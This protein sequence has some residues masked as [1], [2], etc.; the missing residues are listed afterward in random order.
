MQDAKIGR[1][2]V[3]PPSIKFIFV[4]IIL[5]GLLGIGLYVNNVSKAFQASSL[6]ERAVISQSALEAKYGLRVNLVA[7]TAA[8]G[9]VDLRL[10]ITDPEKAKL[11]LQDKKNFPV[12]LAND[13]TVT[14]NVSE[15]TKS[16]PIEFVKDGNIFLLFPNAG[17][18]V[19]PGA[20]VTLMFGDV[21]LEPLDAR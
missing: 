21:A 12:L 6:P 18:A 14:L 2:A 16:Q 13:G 1:A 20:S 8:G 15:E 3:Q 10:K 9:M 4:A 7:V 11:F 19:K 5:I 17:N